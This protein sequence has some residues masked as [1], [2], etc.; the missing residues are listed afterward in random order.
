[1]N[2]NINVTLVSLTSTYQIIP[3]SFQQMDETEKN[4]KLQA[5]SFHADRLEH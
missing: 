5:A 1:M 2:M 4:Q 3:L